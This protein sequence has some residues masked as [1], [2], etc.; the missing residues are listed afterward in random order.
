MTN[1]MSTSTSPLPLT[2]P[3]LSV[4]DLPP[5]PKNI[6]KLLAALGV[7]KTVARE[8]LAALKKP[9]PGH[10]TENDRT[11]MAAAQKAKPKKT[12]K[13][14]RAEEG[15]MPP[16]KKKKGDFRVHCT[17]LSV[18]RRCEGGEAERDRFFDF[19][20]EKFPGARIA[21]GFEE[22]DSENQ[23]KHLHA[24]CKKDKGRFD[25]KNCKALD[26]EG[27]HP[28]IQ[29]ARSHVIWTRYCCK[30]GCIKAN[31][32]TLPY[33]KGNFKG[34]KKET[35]A[36]LWNSVCENIR[37]GQSV[38]VIHDRLNKFQQN[39]LAAQLLS[40]AFA[41]EKFIKKTRIVK[42]KPLTFSN[43]PQGC[44]NYYKW[45]REF[46]L[47]LEGE[48][49]YG[50]TKWAERQF[51]HPLTVRH[52]GKL[53][54]YDPDVHDGIVF[55][56]MTF[57][58]YPRE[59]RIHLLGVEDEADL[60]VKHGHVTIPAGVPR[61]F[62]TNHGTEATFGKEFATDK[63]LS[64]RAKWVFLYEDIRGP[65]KTNDPKFRTFDHGPNL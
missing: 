1:R 39:L 28:N 44:V 31:F 22:S 23:Y 54:D 35:T 33:E 12:R 53:K 11:Q 8:G 43:L 50:K 48:A 19:L 46:A 5:M 65:A 42:R 9:A 62:V 18:T 27:I 25:I 49:G 24:S 32:D 34:K 52:M 51:K 20:V 41:Y 16:A 59:P 36:M 55:D 17:T 2:A 7:S 57:A 64:R 10:L 47:I 63:A 29:K 58:H 60:N 45:K 40:K 38:R 56:D 15:P 37:A 14:A 4:P 26:F 6:R 13:R 3:D 61:I 21:V 30:D